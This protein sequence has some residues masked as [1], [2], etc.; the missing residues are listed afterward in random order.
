MLD[1]MYKQQ[2]QD[3]DEQADADNDVDGRVVMVAKTAEGKQMKHK[4]ST[5]AVS[6]WTSISTQAERP[7]AAHWQD[8]SGGIV[9]TADSF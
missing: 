1:S 5:A 2:R 4:Q 8:G 7:A 6:W 9:H 3:G